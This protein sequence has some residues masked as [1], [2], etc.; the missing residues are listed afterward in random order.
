MDPPDRY[1]S[2]QE[3]AADVSSYLDGLPVRAYRENLLERAER[4]FS[5]YRVA[6]L[7]IAAYLFMRLVLLLVLRH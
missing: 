2:V 6:I 4:L 1:A 3:L 7:L 5:R